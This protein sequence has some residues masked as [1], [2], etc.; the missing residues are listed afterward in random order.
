[1]P[2]IK[3]VQQL[4]E[5]GDYAFSIHRKDAYLHILNVKHYHH[6]FAI[7][8][9]EYALSVGSFVLW[10]CYSPWSFHFPY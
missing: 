6:F 9:A 10:P 3:Q 5:Q 8:L 1:M 4:I 7:C 2:T